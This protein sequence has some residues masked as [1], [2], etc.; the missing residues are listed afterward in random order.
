[1]AKTIT[2]LQS[3][4][5]KYFSGEL[6][7]A[8][9]KESVELAE[10]MLIHVDGLYPKKM[11]D[12]RRPSE[13]TEIKAYR[14]K[15]WEPVTKSTM[16]KV[17]T[18]LMKIRKSEEWSVNYKKEIPAS[19]KPE[20]SPQE[21]FEEYFPFFG[22]V[23]NWA[24]DVVL[25]QLATDVNAVCLVM[26]LKLNIEQN[27]YFKPYGMIF[28]SAQVLDYV[29]NDYCILLSPSKS[30]YY[31]ADGKSK[32]EGTIHYVVTTTE[33][34]RYEQTASDK[35]NIVGTWAHNLGELPAFKLGGKY[36]K[37][38]ESSFLYESLLAVMLPRLNEAIREYSDLQAEVVQHIHSEA[39]IYDSQECKKCNGSGKV[40]IAGED[41][42]VDDQTCAFCNGD[43]YV[44]TSPYGHI[45]VRPQM[46]GE[47]E[48]PWPPKVYIERQT[49]IVKI[50]D[51]RIAA[52]EFKALAAINMEFLA[53]VPLAQ[54][55]TAKAYDTDGLN[56]FVN[57]FAEVLVRVM[58]RFYCIATN[59]RYHFVSENERK[60]LLLPKIN[61]P[62]HFD[63]INA[64]L[65]IEKMTSARNAK[66][67]PVIITAMEIEYANAEFN[68]DPDVRDELKAIYALDPFPG[69][70]ADERAALLSNDLISREDAIVSA[71]IQQYIK[72]A[73]RETK[74]SEKPFLSQDHESQMNVL[75]KYAQ[76]Q[77]TAASAAQ[78]AKAE[79]NTEAGGFGGN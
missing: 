75:R 25:K 24:F 71:N 55:G 70:S 8:A 42:N 50:Q 16:G 9:Y 4:L 33:L 18:E 74:E 5:G 30:T 52:H 69:V 60:E 11:M 10:K 19:I 47:K 28:N 41:G 59:I 73:I 51:E 37:V 26:P 61:V 65:M 23:T 62:E 31:S 48:I 54:S 13:S 40:I 3:S 35:H 76:V 36:K 58:D 2:D 17:L 34:Y 45:V 78:K 49:E 66:V 67:H 22:S 72:R 15:I 38:Y 29:D 20:E 21:Y 14:K 53:Q 63:Y 39:A 32:F 46:A 1:M 44:N 56:T 79:L 7:H 57:S 12:E 64:N 43:G 68:N 77:I 27:E 6:K